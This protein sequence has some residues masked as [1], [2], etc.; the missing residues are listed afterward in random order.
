LRHCVGIKRVAKT[1]SRH[2]G[3]RH[4]ARAPESILPTV[5]M[6]SGL[7]QARAAE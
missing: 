4:L 2:S 6:D 7:A 3:M 1:D 5:V